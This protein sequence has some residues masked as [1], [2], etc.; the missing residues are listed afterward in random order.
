MKMRCGSVKLREFFPPGGTLIPSDASQRAVTPKAFHFGDFQL[1]RHRR[2][3]RNGAG[4]RL[5]LTAKAFD[6]L[7][8]FV[9][10]PG[11]VIERSE[12]LDAL[13]PGI[14]VEENNLSQT[15]AALRR[16]LG[17]GYVATVRGRGY[18]FVAEVR[19]VDDA[20]TSADPVGSAPHRPLR[21]W[22]TMT[23][24][25]VALAAVGALAAY[26]HVTPGVA[27]ASG[28]NPRA[29][30][31]VAG[32][33][34]DSADAAPG[35][36]HRP[37]IAVLPCE[38]LSR[39]PAGAHLA[40]GIHGEIVDALSALA[41]VETIARSSMLYYAG[42][43]RS[44]PEIARELDAGAIMECSVN[45]RGDEVSVALIDPRGGGRKWTATYALGDD[46][47]V[48]ILELQGDVAARLS[49]SLG[50]AYTASEQARLSAVPT[51]SP[52]AYAAYLRAREI[53]TEEQSFDSA[54]SVVQLDRA[55]GADPQFAAAYALRARG[56]LARAY[57]SWRPLRGRVDHE[58]ARATADARQAVALEPELGLAHAVI[59]AAQFAAGERAAGLDRLQYAVSLRGDDA[60]V[61]R[62]AAGLELLQGRRA[63]SLQ[64]LQRLKRIDPI[65]YDGYYLFLAGD[66]EGAKAYV[67]RHLE[68]VPADAASHMGR[69]YL[70]AL[71]GDPAVAEEEA[72]LSE[73][74]LEGRPISIGVL[75]SLIYIYGRI[76]LEADARRLFG[77]LESDYAAARDDTLVWWVFGYLGIGDRE[78]AYEAAAAMAER[79]LPP[80]ATVEYELVHNLVGDPALD[81]PRFL[82]LRRKLG[83]DG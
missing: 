10:H 69:G 25:V 80:F 1:D 59:G 40:P 17:D 82:K 22:L 65:E 48:S 33:G 70:H 20:D 8:Y 44:I 64:I 57:S 62:M 56:H 19:A 12:L 15:V 51:H 21:R 52:V 78:H 76:G 75:T 29:R 38:S 74:L 47:A 73:A 13:W 30:Q 24:A 23:G 11:V 5:E 41:G 54:E 42:S 67:R 55:I 26:L 31:S 37:R 77:R 46:L 7:A 35:T 79:P 71:L 2:E 68:L 28:E 50:T 83:F 14:V 60:D 3:L 34:E 4:K 18:Q 36:G 49:Q 39:D 9:T 58:L 66:R 81:Q 61:L 16:V 53:N 45:L 43:V 63:R 6:A 72:R 32:P 27:G